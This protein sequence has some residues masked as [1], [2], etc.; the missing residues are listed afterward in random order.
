MKNEK[1][2][3]LSDNQTDSEIGRRVAVCGVLPWR[4]EY[5]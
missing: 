3:F 4:A 1:K 2:S 5:R